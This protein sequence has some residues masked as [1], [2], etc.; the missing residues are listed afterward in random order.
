M[1]KGELCFFS[2]FIIVYILCLPLSASQKVHGLSI[3]GPKSLKYKPGEPFNY[4]NPNAPI[5]GTLRKDCEY[6][7]KLLPFGLTGTCAPD[8]QLLC[9]EQLGIKSWDDDEPF[10]VYGLLAEAFEL[11]DD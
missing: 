1:K 8:L 6:Y 3:F 7:T 4:L 2:L 5:Y 11:A 10:A 9:F